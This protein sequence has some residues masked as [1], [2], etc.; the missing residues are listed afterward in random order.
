MTDYLPLDK[1][2]RDKTQGVKIFATMGSKNGAISEKKGD[3]KN[4]LLDIQPMLV[5]VCISAFLA[6]ENSFIDLVIVS[7]I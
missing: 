2:N 4:W 6:L 1:S 7:S 5:L 3:M